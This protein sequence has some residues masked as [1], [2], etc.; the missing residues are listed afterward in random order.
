M[1]NKTRNPLEASAK[2]VSNPILLD[3]TRDTTVLYLH[4]KMAHWN[5]RDKNFLSLHELLDTVAANA[6]VIID[7]IAERARQLGEVLDSNASALVKNKVGTFPTG[8]LSS[9]EACKALSASFAAV[10]KEFHAAIDKTEEAGDAVTTDLLT[11]S[12]GVLEK[13]LW[14]VESHLSS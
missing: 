14:K 2:K 7:E 13:D 5:L 4:V 6:L 12:S 11:Q 8:I 10:V 1:A 9:D 3:L